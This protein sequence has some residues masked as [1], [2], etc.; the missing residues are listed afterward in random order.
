[1]IGE[2]PKTK[3]VYNFVAGLELDFGLV[4]RHH[5][6]VV[7]GVFET[8]IDA[9]KLAAACDPRSAHRLASKII[10]MTIDTANFAVGNFYI[11]FRALGIDLTIILACNLYIIVGVVWR[12]VEVNN[13]LVFASQSGDI[14]CDGLYW[15]AVTHELNLHVA[16]YRGVPLDRTCGIHL[17]SRRVRVWTYDSDSIALNG[18]V[19]VAAEELG[20]SAR[21]LVEIVEPTLS[22]VANTAKTFDSFVVMFYLCVGERIE[23]QYHKHRVELLLRRCVVGY[24]LAKLAFEPLGSVGLHI[25]GHNGE[26]ARCFVPGV[27]VDVTEHAKRRYLRYWNQPHEIKFQLVVRHAVAAAGIE[28]ET[29][30]CVGIA[31]FFHLALHKTAKLP[32]AAAASDTP[33]RA[34]V[35]TIRFVVE[36]DGWNREIAPMVENLVEKRA[37]LDRVLVRQVQ[38]LK[39][40]SV[41]TITL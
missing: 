2:N 37:A 4:R 16:R 39:Q 38:H 41:G 23:C 1:M 26:C 8:A 40:T 24:A 11:E 15:R 18:F 3:L 34:A 33:V 31:V 35:G 19:K 29:R 9:R 32:L 10:H 22:I 13:P 20:A 21:G 6:A 28:T 25:V 17:Q 27:A 7:A 36:I 5:V 14:G 12:A 30:D